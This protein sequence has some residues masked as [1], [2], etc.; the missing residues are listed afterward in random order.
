MKI[1]LG[2]GTTILKEYDNYDKF[3]VNDD[4]SFL[5]LE[6]LPL[7]FNDNY[8]DV[9][10]IHSVIEHLNVNVPDL[11]NE[12]HRILKVGGFLD[13]SLPYFY[14]RLNHVRSY[15]PR[16]YFAPFI[17][18][19]Y[20]KRRHEVSNECNLLFKQIY[21]H[22]IFHGFSMYLPFFIFNNEWKLEKI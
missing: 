11:V 15:H 4:V 16:H 21:V 3:P 5:N 20:T 14:P 6:D 12:L 22:T 19:K 7:P 18:W 13:I 17:I 1:N 8:A 9:I 2:C 10:K